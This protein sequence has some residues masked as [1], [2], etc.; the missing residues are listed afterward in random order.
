MGKSAFSAQEKYEL[1][2]AFNERQTSIQDFCSQYNISDETMKE[3]IYLYQKYGIEGLNKFG[4]WKRYSKEVKTA[5]VL[6]YLSGNDSLMGIVHKYELSSTSVL[7]QWI[8]NYNNHRDL[9]E[10]Q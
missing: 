2:L 7:R 5:A 4:K 6:D 1:I 8:N 9:I 10:T 3:W